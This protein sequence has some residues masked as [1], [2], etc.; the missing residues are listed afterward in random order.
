MHLQSRHVACKT[1]RTDEQAAQ[2]FFSMLKKITEH[3][4]YSPQLAMN[5][6]ETHL[7]W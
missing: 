4:N 1:A 7:F 3:G 6:N 5:M 2:E